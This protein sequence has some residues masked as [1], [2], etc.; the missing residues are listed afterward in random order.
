MGH[1]A[2]LHAAGG[3]YPVDR[4]LVGVA[5]V[6]SGVGDGAG[7]LDGGAQHDVGRFGGCRRACGKDQGQGGQRMQ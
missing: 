3:V 1:P 4:D 6:A 7:Q 5:V 2:D